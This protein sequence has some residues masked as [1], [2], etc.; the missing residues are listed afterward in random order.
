MTGQQPGR[1]ENLS[2][3]LARR[4][5][6]D[7]SGLR[8]DVLSYGKGPGVLLLHELPG[9]SPRFLDLAVRVREA[10]FTVYLPLF[11]G[12]PGQFPYVRGSAALLFCLRREFYLL[13]RNRSSPIAN[14]LRALCATMKR[15]CKHNGVGVIGLCLTANLVLS[16]MLEP[17]VLV[18]VLCEPAIPLP[19]P[20]CG[21]KHKSS[22]GISAADLRDAK[23]RAASTPILGFRFTTDAICPA[24][25][26]ISLRCAFGSNFEETEICTGAENPGNIRNG[27]HAVLTE[28]FCGDPDHPTNLALTKILMRFNERL[29]AT[30]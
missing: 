3:E 2:L 29:R 8:H 7:H 23:R 10:G 16:I 14:W 17:S 22:L 26:F 25:R 19:F 9:M 12:R 18:P 30:E 28:D 6:F 24:E 11:F 20:G 27:A 5:S 4:F 21:R 15:E 13:S 1:P